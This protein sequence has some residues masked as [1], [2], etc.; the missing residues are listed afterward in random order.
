M[1]QRYL[2]RSTRQLSAI[3]FRRIAS[4]TDSLKPLA[5][6]S[7]DTLF[8][9]PAYR[10]NS[11]DQ[12]RDFISSCEQLADTFGMSHEVLKAS[13]EP[14]EQGTWHRFLHR[15]NIHK[16]FNYKYL[17]SIRGG[18]GS[19]Y[20]TEQLLNSSHQRAPY[21]IGYSDLSL[22]HAIW[23]IKGWGETCYGLMPGA[24]HG[25]VSL[26][27]LKTC[28]SGVSWSLDATS[29]PQVQILHPGSAQGQ[30]F[31]SCLR[32]L[33]STVGTAAQ[34]DLSGC[35]L[36]IEDIDEKPYSL[37]RDMR[38]LALA[39][40]LEGV[41]GLVIG[42]MAFAESETYIGPSTQEI[43]RLWGEELQIPVIQAL[44]FGHEQD[45]LSLPIGRESTLQV[46]DNS[47]SWAF[48]ERS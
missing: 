39:G 7:V 27:T 24:P 9:C 29:Y 22:W 8:L 35:I 14:Q 45:P 3:H 40:M 10:P 13:L 46:D 37:E 36:A 44:P 21:L 20:W 12:A 42:N 5:M 30:S 18:F 48:A 23:Q 34:P 38:Q 32:V 19:V 26:Q 47:W 31:V 1:P 17:W 16:L 4:V 28:L 33:A 25:D 6:N 2:G 11:L 43:F 41:Q 15:E